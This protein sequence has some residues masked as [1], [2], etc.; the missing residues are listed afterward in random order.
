MKKFLLSLALSILA[1]GSPAFA[2]LS[3]DVTNPFLR[4]V[5]ATVRISAQTRSQSLGKAVSELVRRGL[6]ALLRTR[7]VN[8][9]HVADLPPGGSP[10]TAE[11]V[12]RIESELE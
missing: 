4:H 11:H 7:V 5:P 8:G 9:F 2:A 1:M 3:V 10:V 6:D 12:K